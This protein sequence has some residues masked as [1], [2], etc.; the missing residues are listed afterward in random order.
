MVGPYRGPS[1]RSWRNT[2]GPP[3]G[4]RRDNLAPRPLRGLLLIIL[5][6]FGTHA[7]TEY[8]TPFLF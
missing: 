8:L 7:S 2:Y 3:V 6:G 1:V 5:L 4:V